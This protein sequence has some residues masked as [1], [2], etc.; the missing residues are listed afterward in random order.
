[1]PHLME[2]KYNQ[3]LGTVLIFYNKKPERNTITTSTTV[4]PGNTTKSTSAG[5]SPITAW[6]APAIFYPFG[7]VAGDTEILET[8]GDTYS[9]VAFSTP[10]TFFGRKYNK[11]YVN[12]N[13][14]ITFNQPLPEAQPYPFPSHGA[15]DYIAPLWTNLNA[16]GFGKYSYR[17]YTNGSVLT[18]AS[19]DINQYFPQRGFT[20]S[21]VFVATWDYAQTWD[22]N[23]TTF[24]VVLISGGGFSFILMNYG[25]CAVLSNLMAAGFDTINST[26]YYVIQYANYG[27]LNLKSMSNVNVPGRWAFLVN[28][29]TENVLGIK[30]KLSSFLDLTQTENIED[31]LQ[32]IKK[33]LVN[34]GVSSFE[35]KLRNVKKT[36]P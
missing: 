17:Q 29:G 23:T 12:N 7:A 9:Y 36:Q 26:H 14:L 21:W 13:G 25:D 32:Q 4:P 35:I 5:I 18:R 27:I 15:E 30:L 1:M 28:N 16:F 31:V 22:L 19:Q 6:T 33:G 2:L 20:A 24:Q 10:F 34:Y 11:T 8:G 3:R